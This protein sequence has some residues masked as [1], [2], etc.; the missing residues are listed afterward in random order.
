M[1]GPSLLS[2][3]LGVSSPRAGRSTE[4]V[5]EGWPAESGKEKEG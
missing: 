1:S 2:P 3:G 4:E 5:R